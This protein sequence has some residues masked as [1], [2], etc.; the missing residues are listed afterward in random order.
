[1]KEA[2][3]KNLPR[4]LELYRNQIVSK[5]RQKHGY[6]NDLAVPR[7]IKIVVNMG[8]GQATQD[9]KIIEQCA[10]ELGVITGQKPKICRSRKPISNFKLKE[11]VPIGCCVT[12]RR[13]MMYEFLDRFITV[14]SPRIRDFRG[15]PAN[16][17]DG[18]GNYTFG[19][20]EQNIFPEI[21]LDKIARTQGMNITINTSAKTDQEA[22]DLLD[23]FGFPFRKQNI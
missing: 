18:R 8:V 16:S 7:L 22:R 13:A 3:E 11:G 20:S 4:Y 6:K 21:N 15:F 12:L 5:L 2:K 14:A 10:E 9:A 23:S 19:L 17:F 1:M